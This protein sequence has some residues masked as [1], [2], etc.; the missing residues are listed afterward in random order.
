MLEHS[1]VNPSTIDRIGDRWLW[2][3]NQ[4]LRGMDG[5]ER[6]FFPR[7]IL[8]MATAFRLC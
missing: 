5:S 4:E 8:P 6:L 1:Y 2:L 3:S 7:R